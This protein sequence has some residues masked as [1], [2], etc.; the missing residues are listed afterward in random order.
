MGNGEI[1]RKQKDKKQKKKNN[2][3]PNK[4]RPGGWEVKETKGN[5]IFSKREKNLEALKG[6][7]KG[8]R[9]REREESLA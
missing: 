6:G 2:R 5:P 1:E 3:T 8:E 9:K 7:K 4:K